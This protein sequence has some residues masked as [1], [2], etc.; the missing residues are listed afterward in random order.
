MYDRSKLSKALIIAFGKK[1]FSL[2]RIDD[3]ILQLEAKW[4][5][6][7]KEIPSTLIGE[8]VLAMLKQEDE[9]AY[10][11]FASVFMEFEGMEDFKKILN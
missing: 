9:I 10:V 7:S 11:R 8:D 5:G 6:M 4:S 2:E 1:W 3:L